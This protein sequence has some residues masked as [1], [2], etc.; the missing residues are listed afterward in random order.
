MAPVRA[1]QPEFGGV[2]VIPLAA[3][4]DEARSQHLAAEWWCGA[5]CRTAL[6]MDPGTT[7]RVNPLIATPA[8]E[9]GSDAV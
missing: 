9:V 8:R 7:N 1:E 2:N 3:T 4:R 6:R 5:P